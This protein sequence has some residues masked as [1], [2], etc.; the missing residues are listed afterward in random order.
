MSEYYKDYLPTAAFFAV[1]ALLLWAWFS[2]DARNRAKIFAHSD[3]L[4][5]RQNVALA[6]TF[7]RQQEASDR[8]TELLAKLAAQKI[9]VLERIAVALEA[10]TRHIS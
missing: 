10:Q 7:K 6:E 5:D 1:V 9:D 2:R 8:Q 3:A 4:M